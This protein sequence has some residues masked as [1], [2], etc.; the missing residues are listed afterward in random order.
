[1][2]STGICVAIALLSAFA[3][4]QSTASKRPHIV[5]IDHVAF[6]IGPPNSAKHLYSDLLGLEIADPIESGEIERYLVGRQWVGYSPAP[7]SSATSRMDHVAFATDDIEALRRHL[8][9]AGIWVPDRI[10]ERSDRS[11]SFMVMD[12]EGNR[13][14][15]VQPRQS[16]ERLGRASD[17]VSHR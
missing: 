14:E 8:A 9:S 12:P 10:A 15:F 5:G 13:I 16:I 11:R 1:M 4:P 3:F 17:P 2:T 6:Y 7:D